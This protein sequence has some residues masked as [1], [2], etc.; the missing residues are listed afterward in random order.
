VAIAL[1]QFN[2]LPAPAP[3]WFHRIAEVVAALLAMR[4][5]EP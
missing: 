3:H 4:G 5:I 1:F 2:Q